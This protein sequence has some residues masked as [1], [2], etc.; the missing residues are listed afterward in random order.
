MH[1]TFKSGLLYEPFKALRLL[2]LPPGLTLKNSTLCSHCV[3]VFFFC[4]DLTTNSDF[5][6]HN[7]SRLV[8]YNQ[9]GEC[10]QRGTHRVL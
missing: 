6:L 10:L 8:L 5:S 9:G 2:Y 7:I 1:F 3:Y 4:T